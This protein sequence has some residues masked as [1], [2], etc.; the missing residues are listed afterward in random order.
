MDTLTQKIDAA[1]QSSDF[2]SLI[3]VFSFGPSSWQ[4]LGQ[5]EQRS[6]AAHLIKAAVNTP[7]FD[8][9][10]AF[11]SNQMMNVFLETLPHL[12]TTPVE[13]AADNKLRQMIFDYKINEQSDFAAAA[14]VLSGM[15]MED[16]KTSIYYFSPAEKCDGK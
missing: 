8:I 5:G 13:G 1:V 12:P 16:D 3:Q 4:S 11:A 7:S 2:G 10:Q 9:Q 15:R 14:R 6:L